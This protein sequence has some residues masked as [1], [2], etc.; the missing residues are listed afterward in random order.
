M[1]VLVAGGFVLG[2]AAGL[3]LTRGITGP[4][5]RIIAGLTD[6]SS[7]VASAAGQVS[8]ASQ[9]LAEGASEQA[10]SHGGDLL[11]AGGDVVDDQ[12]ERRQRQPGQQR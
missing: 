12:A 8:S 7:E 5:N 3:F 11:V 6:G 2:L 9:S 10:A 4:V 1:I